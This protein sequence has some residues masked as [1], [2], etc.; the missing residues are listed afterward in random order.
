MPP[1]PTIA[2]NHNPNWTFG[3]KC[4]PFFVWDGCRGVV[5]GQ[6]GRTQRRRHIT[7]RLLR[8]HCLLVAQPDPR[9]H[10]LHH[11]Q[12]DGRLQRLVLPHHHGPARD[13]QLHQPV[14]LRR[15]VP[16]VPDRRQTHRRQIRV[17]IGADLKDRFTPATC[18]RRLCAATEWTEKNKLLEIDGMHWVARAPEPHIAGDANVNVEAT[19]HLLTE[20]FDLFSTCRWCGWGFESDKNE[21]RWDGWCERYLKPHSHCTNW[22]G[23]GC[24]ILA[25]CMPTVSFAFHSKLE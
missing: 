18:W 23:S 19:F 16:R 11:P 24:V 8:L 25:Y 14:H 6:R 9:L 13:Q 4:L 5:G 20:P 21:V 12:R 17:G 1:A 15:Q 3:Q 2:T 10:Q 22:T 7:D